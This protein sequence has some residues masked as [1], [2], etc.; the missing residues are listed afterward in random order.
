M[1]ISIHGMAPY[2]LT[3]NIY[4]KLNSEKQPHVPMKCMFIYLPL[5]A[6]SSFIHSA[7]TL[8]NKSD[9]IKDC[10]SLDIFYKTFKDIH[11]CS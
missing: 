5:L 6:N 1:R 3:N 11:H 2:Y 7:C 9:A 4:W 8:W 10:L